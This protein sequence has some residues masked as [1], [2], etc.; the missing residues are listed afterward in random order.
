MKTLYLVRHAKSSWEYD[1]IDHQ[2]PLNERGL[3]D[4]PLI[5]AHVAGLIETP[6]LFMSSDAVRALTTAN[7][8]AKAFGVPTEDIRLNHDLYDF[9]G[10]QLVREV[11][12]LPNAHDRVMVFGHNHAMTFFVNEF[13]S[14]PIGNVPTAAFTAIQFDIDDWENLNKGTTLHHIAPKQLK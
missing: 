5:A 3:S 11:K 6:D 7:F 8:Y 4:A 10:R 12:K 13:G 14:K 1:V 2:R 9:D